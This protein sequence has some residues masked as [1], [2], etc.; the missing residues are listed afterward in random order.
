MFT[1]SFSLD[2]ERFKFAKVV[3]HEC[4]LGAKTDVKEMPSHATTWVFFSFQSDVQN[5]A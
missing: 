5:L 1:S 4:L 2:D 3:F